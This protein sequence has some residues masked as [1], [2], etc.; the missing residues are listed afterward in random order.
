MDKVTQITILGA[1]V[2]PISFSDL[3]SNIEKTI[4]CRF[5]N[6]TRIIIGHQNL[7]GVFLIYNQPGMKNMMRLADFIYID[8]MSLVLVGRLSG[9]NLKTIHRFTLIDKIEEILF[10]ASILN[11]SVFF[12]GGKPGVA[13]HASR[14]LKKKI[15]GLEVNSHHG[16]F[17]TSQEGVE[18]QKVIQII[19]NSKASIL[20]VGMGMPRQENW[21]AENWT[22][23][24]IPVIWTCGATF[25]YIAKEIQTPPRWSGSI[26]ME[27]FF[28]LLF[29]PKR[30]SKRY[31][32]EPL[33][34]LKRILFKK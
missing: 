34:I 20:F 29:E 19:N 24:N 15:K 26:G 2:T 18:N 27:W 30:L 1:P 28:R 14:V 21:I 3:M 32:I 5:S 10:R 23:L 6:D 12:L 9:K 22:K 7:H 16:F 17:C 25:D 11:K 4:Y 8:G 33:I 31:L 13:E